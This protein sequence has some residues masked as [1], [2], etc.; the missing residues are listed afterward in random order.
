MLHF[1]AKSYFRKNAACHIPCRHESHPT[2]HSIFADIH[3]EKADPGLD[4]FGDLFNLF[5]LQTI[6]CFN[7]SPSLTLCR[8][9]ADTA[10]ATAFSRT[11][12]AVRFQDVFLT[13]PPGK[14]QFPG[15]YFIMQKI[16]RV[17][18]LKYIENMTSPAL[19]P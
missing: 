17:A 7:L 16:K 3:P 12:Q 10:S 2:G 13:K 6:S 18:T 11:G 5:I 9:S 1:S 8:T 14:G 15:R 4:P 19:H